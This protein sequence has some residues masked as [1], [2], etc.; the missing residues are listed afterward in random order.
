MNFS[1][2]K[3]EYL[4]SWQER[5][6]FYSWFLFFTILFIAA[7]ISVFYYLNPWYLAP[8]SF[9]FYFLFEVSLSLFLQFVLIILNTVVVKSRKVSDS[10]K[11][12]FSI[13]TIFWQFSIISIFY[14]RY[15]GVM[16][17]P[18]LVLILATSI[19]NRQ[20][21][22]SL[23]KAC[24]FVEFLSFFV[25]WKFNRTEALPEQIIIF[26]LVIFALIFIYGVS[27]VMMKDINTQFKV[28]SRNNTRLRSLTNE[29]R[30]EP[31]TRLYNRT[32]YSGA[33]ERYIKLHCENG[34]KVFQALLDLD[35]FKS[36]NDT[37]GHAAGDAVLI[38]LSEKISNALG[39]N[40]SAFRYGGDEF[41]ILFR[42]L[43][44]EEVVQKIEEIRLAF[45]NSTFDFMDNSFSCTMSIG[46][47]AYKDG[48]TSKSWFKAADDAAY[49]AKK[50]GKNRLE[51]AK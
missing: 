48:M 38:T 33:I 49:L 12:R 42:N 36:V 31:L 28:M 19:A 46:I 26:I 35:N 10:L 14:N 51:L 44:A 40:R 21:L 17:L 23:F 15:D 20:L 18:S 25:H 43:E 5:L 45:A 29:L 27:K 41:V 1:E 2:Y 50:G 13:Y 22:K 24:V 8:L 11:N 3:T 39:G 30:L 6:F 37:Y 34:E 7:G 16:V 32:A 9:K 4:H 47:A